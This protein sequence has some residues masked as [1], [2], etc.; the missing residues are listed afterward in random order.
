MTT[1]ATDAPAA[2]A[3]ETPAPAPAQP[4]VPA[5]PPTP[6]PPVPQPPAQ[7]APQ[8][9]REPDGRFAPQAPVPAP[10]QQQ[11]PDG[12]TDWRAEAE[13]ARTRAAELQRQVEQWKAQSRRQEQRSK[14]NH[15]ELQQRDAVLRLIAEKV[16]VEFDDRPDPEALQQRLDQQTALARQR[17]VELAVYTHSAQAGGVNAGALL[18]SREFMSRTSALDPDAADFHSQLADLVKEAAGQPRYQFR[19]PP[20]A[21]PA[22]PVQP[23]VQPPVQPQV[24]QQVQPPA[25]AS[26]ADFSGA[27][28]GNRLWTEADYANYLL[29]AGREDRDGAKLTKAIEDGLLGNIGIG[30]PKRRSGR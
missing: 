25:P 15:T 13:A 2:P 17:A 23:Q 24:Q 21:E 8:Q 10:P 26:G 30:K 1:P 27:P 19:Q 6:Q 22:A 20:A 29:T 14:L 16:G 18:D 28:G 12:A 3:T 9:P 5:P 4:A 7:P 11:A